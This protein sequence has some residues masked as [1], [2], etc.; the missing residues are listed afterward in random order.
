MHKRMSNRIKRELNYGITDTSW[1]NN[2]SEDDK[3][4]L[5][6]LDQDFVEERLSLGGLDLIQ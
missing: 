4:C 1:S 5:T 6:I 3:C 2:L